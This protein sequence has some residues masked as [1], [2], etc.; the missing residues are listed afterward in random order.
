MGINVS[1]M[2]P[3]ARGRERQGK[4]SSGLLQ[5]AACGS[6]FRAGGGHW[7]RRLIKYITDYFLNIV[8]IDKGKTF[9]VNFLD[10][11]DIFSVLLRDDDGMDA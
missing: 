11:L 2:P 10:I 4:Q 6:R 7:N 5:R 9:Y 1:D 8:N 3:T